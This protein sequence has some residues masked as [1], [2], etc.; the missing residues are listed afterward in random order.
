[1][2]DLAP[3]PS[4]MAGWVPP[5]PLGFLP[6]DTSPFAGRVTNFGAF[7]TP[8]LRNVALTGPYMHNGGLSTLRQVTDFY[9][10]GGDFPITNNMNFDSEGITVL[11]L[12][13]DAG[14][15]S[16]LPTPEE[17]RDALTQF[18]MALTDSRVANESRPFDH[19]ELFVP[20]TGSAPLSP[21]R[22]GMLANTTDFQRILPV[23]S[24]GRGSVGLPPLGSFLGLNPRSEGLVADADLDLIED[25]ADNCPVTGNPGQDDGDA[26]GVGDACDNCTE[27]A[28]AD[29]RDSNGD[30]YGNICDG[31]L[32][33][34]GA[35]NTLDLALFKSVLP[36]SGT[37][38]G[39][40]DDADFNGGG[41]V[42]TLD[43]AIFK[44]LLT[45]PPGPSCIDSGG[46]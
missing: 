11:P 17:Q 30:G 3:L 26:D 35:T 46:C 37:L 38:T 45:A 15:I 39:L 16:G 22:A 5:L 13:R 20:I 19:P 2:T 14:A 40:A 23:G 42:N 28:N 36:S 7:K 33:N 43:L 18:M 41:V 31:D 9:V 44:G 10:R 1:M 32:N 4:H 8:H 21:G 34:N 24:G 25:T 29:Q 27:V 12:L 6:T